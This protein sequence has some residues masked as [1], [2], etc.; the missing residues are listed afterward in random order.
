MDK[1]KSSLL[2]ILLLV[3]GIAFE[4][5]AELVP[6]L[7]MARE[8]AKAFCTHFSFPVD[9]LKEIDGDPLSGPTEIVRDKRK[10]IVYRWLGGGRGDYVVQAEIQPGTA[11]I[12][13]NGGYNHKEFGP[14]RFVKEPSFDTRPR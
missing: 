9:K 1:V 11:D 12:I 10:V 5:A 13:V 4:A 3:N 6:Y 14:W 2:I 8:A 7:D